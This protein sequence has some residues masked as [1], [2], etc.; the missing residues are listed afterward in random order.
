M[1]IIPKEAK[2]HTITSDPN[3][4]VGQ[5]HYFSYL[6]TDIE[7]YRCKFPSEIMEREGLTPIYDIL[8]TPAKDLKILEYEESK[9]IFFK[10]YRKNTKIR[11]QIG[12]ILTMFLDSFGYLNRTLNTREQKIRNLLSEVVNG[13]QEYIYDA[14]EISLEL[15]HWIFSKPYK[16]FFNAIQ[17]NGFDGIVDTADIFYND[18]S[19]ERPIISFNKNKM[20]IVKTQLL[21]GF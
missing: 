12:M 10:I 16:V 3:Y 8:S 1:F 4:N 9:N 21:Q 7:V 6:K 2:C 13:N 15:D 5:V 18:Y 11:T 14:F 17:R 19:I 20:K